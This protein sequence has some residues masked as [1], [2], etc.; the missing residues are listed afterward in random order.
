MVSGLGV[1]MSLRFSVLGSFVCSESEQIHLP[2]LSGDGCGPIPLVGSIVGLRSWQPPGGPRTSGS[3]TEKS[4]MQ[5]EGPV[6]IGEG[7]P[8][9]VKSVSARSKGP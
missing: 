5:K 2:L 4:K 7:W 3:V 1:P 6:E 8:W 9:G